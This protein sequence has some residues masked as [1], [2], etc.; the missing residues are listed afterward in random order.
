MEE[1]SDSSLNT[2]VKFDQ[3]ILLS[4]YLRYKTIYTT[5]HHLDNESKW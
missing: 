1:I 4:E 2:D 3:E 5:C